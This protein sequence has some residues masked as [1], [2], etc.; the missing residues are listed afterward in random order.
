MNVFTYG[1]LMF[2]E[3]W[4]RVVRGSYLSAPGVVDDCARY[5]IDRETYPGMVRERGASVS[6]IVYFDVDPRDLVALDVFEGSDYERQTVEVRL[7]G[8]DT[9]PA[10]TYFYLAKTRLL[11]SPWEP[12]AFQMQRFLD[13]YC[14][15]RLGN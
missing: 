12:D 4:Q 2:P 5:A 13:T 14:R 6:G 7:A 1:S 10:E 9:A 11:E 3:V 8:V 15:S